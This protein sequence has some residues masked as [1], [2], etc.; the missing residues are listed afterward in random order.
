[1]SWMV[2]ILWTVRRIWILF[3]P[4]KSCSMSLLSCHINT[5]SLLRDRCFIKVKETIYFHFI[6]YLYCLKFSSSKCL[7][8]LRQ[9]LTKC[10]SKVSFFSGYMKKYL[11]QLL[12]GQGKGAAHGKGQDFFFFFLVCANASTFC[13]YHLCNKIKMEYFSL[14]LQGFPTIWCRENA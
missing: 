6:M 13:N 8:V 7:E 5:G 12:S 14:K 4:P 9:S 2:I 3:S 10:T 11:K 1:M